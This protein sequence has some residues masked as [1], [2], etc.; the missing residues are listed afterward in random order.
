MPHNLRG[1]WSNE[2]RLPY[3]GSFQT[4]KNPHKTALSSD[5]LAPALHRFPLPHDREDVIVFGVVAIVASALLVLAL[6]C[7]S[8]RVLDIA[9]IVD[10]LNAQIP[11]SV[12]RL[13]AIRLDEG[14]TLMQ[15][16][17]A[18][19]ELQKYGVYLCHS[20]RSLISNN[21]GHVARK[22]AGAVMTTMNLEE[23]FRYHAPEPGQPEKYEA[24]RAAAKTFAQVIVDNTP[25]CADQTAAIRKLREAVMTANAAIALKGQV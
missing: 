5:R 10:Y 23:I 14:V 9:E 20:C 13:D 11:G 12:V 24:I 25:S 22:E 15:L 6:A 3:R 19:R 8:E 4:S 7:F 2:P 1:V 21:T 16:N 17:E 18:I